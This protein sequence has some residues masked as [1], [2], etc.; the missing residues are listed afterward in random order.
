MRCGVKQRA[1]ATRRT[2]TSGSGAARCPGNLADLAP[3]HDAGVFGFKCFLVDSGVPEFPPLDAD[4]FAAAMAE[5]ARLG[6]LLIVHAEDAAVIDAR[7]A[8]RRRART[9]ASCAPARR[10]AEN[11]R[12]RAGDRAGPAHRRPRARAAPVAAPRRC[13]RCA[14]HARPG[15]TLSVETCPHYLALRRRGRC[16]TARPSS[17]AA[18]RSATRATRTAVGR[19]GRRRHRPGGLRPLAVHRRSSSALDDGDFGA[20]WGG[21]ASLQLVAA[22]RVDRRARARARPRRRRAVDGQRARPTGS[23]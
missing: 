3:L 6:A 14:P 7:A 12:D 21:I 5:M 11:R 1:P 16:R 2:S 19:A 18:R 22:R 10:D 4:G 8:G 9:P 23:G 17:S 13:R 15:P 20:A